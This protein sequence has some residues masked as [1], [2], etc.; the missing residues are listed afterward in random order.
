MKKRIVIVAL[1]VALV[2]TCFAGTM[3]YLQDEEFAHNVMTYGN[4]AI[5]QYEYERK[6]GIAYNATLT[7]GDLQP[8]TQNQKIYPSV[9]K[10]GGS[11]TLPN[12]KNEG[13][14]WG[15]YTY[16]GTSWDTLYNPAKV[17]NAMDKFVFVKNTGSE[18]LYF[19]TIV[20]LECPEG[21]KGA[22]CGLGDDIGLIYG[23]QYDADGL[24]YAYIGETRYVIFVLTYKDGR[25]L[26]SGAQAHPSLLQVLLHKDLGNA[27]LAKLNGT[28]DVE[29]LT[30]AVQA[31]GFDNMDQ[32]LVTA[33]G[34]LD[35][36]KAAGLIFN[37]R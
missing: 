34:E 3:A 5:E 19:R 28:L 32:A 13:I 22:D 20:A 15:T 14:K 31:Q 30:Q 37:L 11:Y 10:N 6:P 7:D 8:F 16:T 1:I 33:F 26:E 12:D 36:Q 25:K 17:A 21:W 35:A 27:D 23:G 9:V 18:P 4:V 29:V 24:G 2:A